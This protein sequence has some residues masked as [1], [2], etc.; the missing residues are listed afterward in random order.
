MIAL[1]IKYWKHTRTHNVKH[2]NPHSQ[3][4]EVDAIRL[5]TRVPATDC[6]Y[7]IIYGDIKL[8]TT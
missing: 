6:K 5:A 7:C 1:K 8:I 2:E 4:N 3:Q